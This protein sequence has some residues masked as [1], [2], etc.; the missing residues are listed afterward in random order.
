MNTDPVCYQP[1]N[2]SLV[3]NSR[4]LVI[5][6]HPSL[7]CF[8]QDAVVR[9]SKRWSG[10]TSSLVYDSIFHLFSKGQISLSQTV[11]L[12]LPLSV[13]C[14]CF[15]RRLLPVFGAMSLVASTPW[16]ASA[17]CF[18]NIAPAKLQSRHYPTNSASF[19]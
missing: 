3:I 12:P 10:V 6:F 5:S 2:L 13:G 9:P 17:M 4:I 14:R 19:T 16:K 1:I 8:K 7:F 18:S 11:A 15:G